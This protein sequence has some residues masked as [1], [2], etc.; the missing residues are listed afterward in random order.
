MTTTTAEAV[1]RES[2]QKAPH[3]IERKSEQRRLSRRIAVDIVGF[4]DAAAVVAGGMIPAVIYSVG[5]GLD[6]DWLKHLQMCLISAVITY[7][8]MKNF[9]MYDTDRMHDLPLRPTRLAASLGITF[10]AVLG[11]GLP[12]APKEM[13]LWIWYA[14]WL[15]MSFTLLLDVRYFAR[16]VL[17][18]LTREGAFDTHVAV[19]GSGLVARRVEEHLSNP[20]LGIRYAGLFD[21][22]TDASRSDAS[23][24]EVSVPQISGR[25]EELVRMA[26]LGE[27]DRII[28][29]LPQSADARTQQIARH[30]EHLP[31]SLHIVTHIASDLVEA[32]PAH[33]VSSVGPVGL[34]DVKSK[35][36]ADWSRVVK[37][38]ED[39]V[40]GAILL[41]VLLPV[42]A[43][44]ALAIKLD[45]KGPV[46]F[47]QR[48]RGLN[49]RV[50]EVLKF[51]TMHVLE[52]GADLKQVTR[53]DP[54]VTR[55]GRALRWLGLDELPQLVNVLRGE[56]SIV[57]P[58]PHALAHD[59]HFGDTVERYANRHQVK[60]GI[61]GLAQIA[62][63]RGET[64]TKEK[65]ERRLALDLEY[66][67]MWSLWL[68]LRILALTVFR[69]VCSKNAY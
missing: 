29:A 41:V 39:Y 68:D 47:H 43:L 58:R 9:G 65:I 32:G 51:R 26:R 17:A 3:V 18:R 30:L 54:R 64:E 52:D 61:T 63:Y 40:L 34:I 7:G 49:H 50:F 37:A 22:R 46:L 14:V 57:G 12:F 19:Y 25:L 20:S 11:L 69:G 60:P 13:H 62:G 59:D 1:L 31:V 44:I 42:F 48:R 27:I 67:N 23:R 16:V 55:V 5:G 24:S 8:C 15:A 4:A 66:V 21:D 36:L 38:F 2:E 10:L 28:I 45:S 56:M 6:V 35:P 33:R 53:D